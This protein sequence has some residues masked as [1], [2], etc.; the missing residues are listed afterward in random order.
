MHAALRSG[1][2]KTQLASWDGCSLVDKSLSTQRGV[3]TDLFTI[4]IKTRCHKAQIHTPPKVKTEWIIFFSHP[5]LF[6][7]LFLSAEAGKYL[8][9]SQ[10]GNKKAQQKSRYGGR[11]AWQE[12]RRDWSQGPT[13]AL[14]S[15]KHHNHSALIWVKRMKLSNTQVCSGTYPEGAY[16]L[17]QSCEK[18]EN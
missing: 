8:W 6:F 17:W 11:W 2:K 15:R 10:M 3:A 9:I 16:F 14:Q 1:K 12:G 18:D 7:P 5:C 13:L 4:P